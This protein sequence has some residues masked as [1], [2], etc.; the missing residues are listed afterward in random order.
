MKSLVNEFSADLE[1]SHAQSDQPWWEQIYRLAFPGFL[2]MQAIKPDGWAQRGGIDRLVTLRDG[3]VLKI[4]EKARRED[5]PD[6]L[7]EQ[8]SDERGK[9]PGWIQKDLTCDY[10]AYAFVPSRTCYL[11]PFQLLRRAWKHQGRF[12]IDAYREVRAQNNGYVT[13]SIAVPIDVLLASL[14]SVMKVEWPPL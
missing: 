11:L 3:T 12:W 10:I 4:D 2:S 5:W 6:I 7:L 13:V 9:R 8:W 14:A 1:W